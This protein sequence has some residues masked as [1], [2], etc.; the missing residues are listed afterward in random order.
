MKK[1]RIIINNDD[2]CNTKV[3]HYKDESSVMMQHFEKSCNTK[4]GYK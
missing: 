2:C 1:K 3:G 4:E